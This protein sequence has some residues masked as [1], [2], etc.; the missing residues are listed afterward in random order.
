MNI[1]NRSGRLEALRAILATKE[2]GTQEELLQEL[3]RAG[4][5]VTQATLSRDLRAIKATKIMSGIGY[6]YIL[7]DH[8]LY[9]RATTPGTVPEYLQM[10]SGFVSLDFSGNLAVIHTRPGY[11]GGLAS[12]IDSN[13]L[14]SVLGTIAG[15]DTILVIVREEVDRQDFI[16]EIAE[17]IPAVKSVTL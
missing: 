14:T 13:N 1:K 8:P 4:H 2:S 10:K 16:D 3:Q 12:D 5:N 9:K 6:R 7:P 11:A 17:V 15:D